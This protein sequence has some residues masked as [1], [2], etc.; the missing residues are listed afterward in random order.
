MACNALLEQRLPAEQRNIELLKS[1][2]L[3][4]SLTVK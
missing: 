1:V 2:A 3:S 4:L